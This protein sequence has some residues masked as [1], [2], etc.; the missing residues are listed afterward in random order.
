MADWQLLDDGG[1]VERQAQIIRTLRLDYETFVNS[2]FLLQ[3]PLISFTVKTAS[4]RKQILADILGLGRYDLYE[5]RAEQEAQ[6]LKEQATRIGGEIAGIDAELARRA[7]Y[8]AR[9]EAARVA[10]AQGAAALRGAEVEQAEARLA[11]QERRA[12][13][14]H[15]ADLRGRLARAGARDLAR[16]P[17][18]T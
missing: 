12:Q 17:R 6:V 2:A 9:L 1:L 8:E 18:P 5:E 15:L 10:A 14:R 16:W 3:G 13:A 11:V 4:E 7:D